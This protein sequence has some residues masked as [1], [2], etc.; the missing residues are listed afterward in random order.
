VLRGVRGHQRRCTVRI[1]RVVDAASICDV[2]TRSRSNSLLTCHEC[3][4][5][6][7]IVGILLESLPPGLETE[8]K[9]LPC[10]FA[11][12]RKNMVT[13]NRENLG[14]A[15]RIIQSVLAYTDHLYHG[16]PGVVTADARHNIGVRW[17]PVTHKVEDGQ[18]VVYKLTKVGK[19]TTKAKL[20]TMRDDGKVM[21]GG[22]NPIAEYR[23]AGLFP[24]VAAWFY[25]QIADV[26]K[27]D[28]EFAARWASYAFGQEHRDLKVVLAAFMLVQTRKGDPVRDGGKVV[29][30]DE[31]YRDVGEAMMLIRRKDDKDL[32]PKLLLRIREVLALPQVAAIN[33]ELGFGV[34]TRHPF[35]GRWPDV[36]EKWL[37]HREENPKLLDGLVKAGF[38]TTVIEL[39]RRIG[40]KP[41]AAHF[42]TTLRWKQEQADGGHRQLLIGEAVAK[43]ETWEG[44]TE[45]QVCEK[46]T[47]DKPDW[48]R[49]VGLLPSTVGV[50]RAVVAAAIESKALSDRDLIIAT[51]TLEELGLLDVPDVRARWE[52]AMRAADDTRAAN[53]ARNVQN[54]EV[55]EKLVEAADTAVKKAVEAVTKN[56]RV[57]VM[58]DIS[59]SMQHSIEAAKRHIA[60]FLQ[61]FP[62]ERTHVAVFNTTG[63]IV[64]IK[65]ASAAGVENAFKGINADG[66][67]DYAAPVRTLAQ[68]KP[69]DD[70]DSLFIF[71]GDEADSARKT[72]EDTVRQSGLRPTAFGLLRVAGEPGNSVTQTAAKL[73]IPCFLI[74]EKT[75]DDAY[76]IPRTIRA[77]IAATPVGAAAQA[78]APR[79][80][81]VDQIL[82]TD[83]LKKP[84]WA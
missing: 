56:L 10:L 16:R 66:G 35:F 2:S 44:L 84:A 17:E 52:K 48:K 36:V 58:V 47:A 38:R 42:F 76:A 59:G 3:D 62:T 29:F 78:A 4:V 43:A 11:S 69:K 25:R 72:F 37:R 51:P 55:K 30:H 31:D 28:N 64:T 13:N 79:M 22:P 45:A 65:H 60:K 26:W 27:L 67:T 82:K 21:N 32:N 49:I 19:K 81:L 9:A 7:A 71:V 20:G 83:L 73:G 23:D 1:R 34:S 61:G 15:E 14:P 33:R 77:L 54:K 5:R 57:Y 46:I 50:T 18:K 63:R 53:I 74:D 39:A 41:N 70:E 68:F 8:A 80:T 24:E 12:V 40:Y 6:T 75:F